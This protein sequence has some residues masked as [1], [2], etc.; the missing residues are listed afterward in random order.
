VR[1]H[2]GPA[3]L[4]VVLA[5]VAGGCRDR[6]LETESNVVVAN[7]SACSV[8]VY[9]DGWEAVTV[10]QGASRTVDNVGS[11]RHVLEAKDHQGRLVARRYVE[12]A[13]GQDF[14]WRIDTCPSR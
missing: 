7:L 8:T 13:S 2:I 5:L 12:L 1:A 10:D 11:G 6:L 3:A 14:T 4:L 9:V